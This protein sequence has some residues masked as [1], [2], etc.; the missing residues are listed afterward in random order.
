MNSKINGLIIAAGLSSRIG[1]FKP[2]LDYK[3]KKFIECII[4]NLIPICSKIIIVTGNK[5]ESIEYLI[6]SSYANN[7][8]IELKLNKNFRQ[9][10]FGSLKK[11]IEDLT[12]NGW[13]L[14]H[15]VDQPN[16]PA[17]FYS[18][19]LLQINDKYDWIQPTYN[20]RK[21]HPILFNKNVVS[22]ILA[23]EENSNLR[24]ISNDISIKKKYW[25]S[26]YPSIFTDIDTQ[27]DF[28]NLIRNNK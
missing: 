3:G 12:D 8:S 10:M 19:F 28:N 6:A 23:A 17:E 2:L 25:Q 7:D 20:Q 22:K 26:H 9:G 21:G 11:G 27:K 4:D 15:F 1:K 5:S 13:V 24:L 14:Y 16:L 18:Q